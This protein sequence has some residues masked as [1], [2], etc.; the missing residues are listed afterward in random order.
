VAEAVTATC[1]E[2]FSLSKRIERLEKWAPEGW[3]RPVA[4]ITAPE[5]RT[6]YMEGTLLS[7]GLGR[8]NVWLSSL[9]V[10]PDDSQDSQEPQSRFSGVHSVSVEDLA[11]EWYNDRGWLGMHC[12]GAVIFSLF[13]LF[14]FDVI[15]TDVPFVFQTKFQ[16]N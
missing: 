14:F 15:F 1:P 2:R 5:P 11:L 6:V 4:F 8:R 16:G 7:G 3:E 9:T 12:E 13:A 10:V